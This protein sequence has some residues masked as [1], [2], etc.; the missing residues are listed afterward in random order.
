MKKYIK[1]F[2]AIAILSSLVFV[3]GGF[4]QVAAQVLDWQ[5]DGSNTY[6]DAGNVGI[7][8]STPAYSLDVANRI[9]RIQGNVPALILEDTA[10]PGGNDWAM[11]AGSPGAGYWKL[12]QMGENSGDRL[13][14]TD[15]GDFISNTRTLT[16]RGDLPA[17]S[18]DDER[19]SGAD[20]ALYT[21]S[22]G[23][24]DFKIRDNNN[25]VNR[26]II[27]GNGNI[28]LGNCN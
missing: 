11:F 17:L 14:V 26:F 25:G 8:T 5:L 4:H 20:F 28:C 12:M 10:N 16:L 19:T 3:G 18:L 24:G 15:N 9:T 27:Y 23:L 2:L 6:Y 7:N 13:V 1:G 21:G 22:P